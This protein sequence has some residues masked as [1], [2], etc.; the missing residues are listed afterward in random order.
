MIASYL[1]LIL[2]ARKFDSYN[3]ILSYLRY[4][5]SASEDDVRD[6]FSSIFGST[7]GF[8]LF[9]KFLGCYDRRIANL[10][11]SL[12]RSNSGFL[13]EG[14]AIRTRCE[15]QDVSIFVYG[16]TCLCVKFEPGMESLF[17]SCVHYEISEKISMIIER[18]P[19]IYFDDCV[20]LLS[21]LNNLACVLV[22]DCA[23][24]L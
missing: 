7:M 6:N 10:L 17:V 22:I 21:R 18:F 5:E 19:G 16:L 11:L 1:G 13:C 2:L 4:L 20:G 3:R 23:V 14:I 15:R 24:N 12:D 8:H 9:N